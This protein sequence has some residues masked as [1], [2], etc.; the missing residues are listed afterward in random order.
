[1][2]KVIEALHPE[3]EAVIVTLPALSSAVNVVLAPEVGL[4]LPV[5]LVIFQFAL[6]R[7]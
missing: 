4:T 2:V 1:M 3:P 7:E 6:P 5:P